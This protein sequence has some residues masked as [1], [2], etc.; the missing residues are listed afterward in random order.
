MQKYML[1]LAP[2][3]AIFRKVMENGCKNGYKMTKI[4]SQK[5]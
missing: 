1:F 4:K 5:V 3:Q 2:F